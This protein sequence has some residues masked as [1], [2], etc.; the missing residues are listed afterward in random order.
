[1]TIRFLIDE[2]LSPE[3]VDAAVTRGYPETTCVRN[4]GWAGT[5]DYE[6]IRHVVAED[7]TLVTCNSV[8]FR[9]GGPGDLGGEHAR[10]EIHAG[11]VCLNSELPLDLDLQHT[12]FELALDTIAQDG[13]DM[14]NQVVDVFHRA[15]GAMEVEVYDIPA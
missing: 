13:L 6:L 4:R 11:L 8:D 10:Q 3:L 14:V 12:L 9:G 1:M 15:D 5:K 2:C 7:F